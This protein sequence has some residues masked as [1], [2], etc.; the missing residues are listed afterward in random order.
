M[1]TPDNT[2]ILVGVGKI[3]EKSVELETAS[4]PLQLMQQ[5]TLAALEDA[6]L[7]PD[8]FAFWR[9]HARKMLP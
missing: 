6:G 8:D 2:P 9:F 1:S 5:A 7:A 3:T 4:S